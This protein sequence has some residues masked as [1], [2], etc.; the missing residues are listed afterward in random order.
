MECV[1]FLITAKGKTCSY[2]R[3]SNQELVFLL[4]FFPLEPSVRLALFKKHKNEVRVTKS[5][6]RSQ[7][8]RVSYFE[9]KV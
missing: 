4:L 2:K 7:L 5:S 9:G 8:R 1:L 6:K 3:R